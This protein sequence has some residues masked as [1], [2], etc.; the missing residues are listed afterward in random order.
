LAAVAVADPDVITLDKT[1]YHID[2]FVPKRPS[3][4]TPPTCSEDV[5]EEL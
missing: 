5:V 3:R 2:D 1:L 4:V